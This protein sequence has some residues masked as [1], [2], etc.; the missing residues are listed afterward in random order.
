[1]LENQGQSVLLILEKNLEPV[2]GIELLSG[3]EPSESGFFTWSNFTFM[4][5][6]QSEDILGI[7][8]CNCG[9]TFLFAGAEMK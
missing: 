9:G 8:N 7:F 3:F 1:M 6:E 4:S 2:L 5:L